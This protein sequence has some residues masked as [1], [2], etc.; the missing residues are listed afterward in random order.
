M[1]ITGM[2]RLYMHTN[3]SLKTPGM[4]DLKGNSPN[5]NPILGMWIA[6]PSILWEFRTNPIYI[7]IGCFQ[8]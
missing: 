1:Y 4:S 3:V 2:F 6:I 8:K 5:Y 7:Y